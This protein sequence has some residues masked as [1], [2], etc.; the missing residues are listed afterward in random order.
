MT[1]TQAL[2]APSLVDRI[3]GAAVDPQTWRNVL[4]LL[5]SFPLGILYFVFTVTGLSVGIGLA[6]IAVGIPILVFTLMVVGLFGRIERGL[7]RGLLHA[8]VMTPPPA[9][10]PSGIVESLRAYLRR[11]ETWKNVVYSLVHFPFGVVGFSLVMAFLPAGAFLLLTPLTYTL[12]PIDICDARV[13]TLDQAVLCSSIGAI[14]TL[15][16]LHVMNGWAM[17]WKR[18]G[19]ALLE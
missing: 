18:V 8:P 3:F 11:P 5:V 16:G 17:L 13:T 15:I 10:L 1:N 12:L 4:Y 7:L 2:E 9:P 14:I 6:L 19:G